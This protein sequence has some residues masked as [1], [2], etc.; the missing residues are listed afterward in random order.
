MAEVKP[1]SSAALSETEQKRE[2]DAKASIKEEGDARAKMLEAQ[3]ERQGRP[4]PTQEENDLVALG[5]PQ[6]T[7]SPD[8]SGPDPRFKPPGGPYGTESKEA[9]PAPSSS[10]GGYQ[11]RSAHPSSHGSSHGSSSSSHA[12]SRE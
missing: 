8:G 2:A 3:A 7:L 10:A 9:K 6:P 5:V 12:A 11:T 4:T 1:T